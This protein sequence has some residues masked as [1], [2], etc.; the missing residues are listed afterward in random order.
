MKKL[1]SVIFLGLCLSISGQTKRTEL[2]SENFGGVKVS[3]QKTEGADGGLI[4]TTMLSFQNQKYQ[5]ISDLKYIA[6]SNKE[7]LSTLISNFE[8]A[9]T[10]SKSGEKSEMEFEGE[11]NKFKITADG[12]SGQ[13]T[14]WSYRGAS[15]FIWMHPKNITKI[16]ETL[17]IIKVNYDGE[18]KK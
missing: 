2:F 17:K 12:K 9:L 15:G 3:Q 1:L 13:I 6:V 18:I 4:I 14:I 11:K 10:F 16:I 5:Q 7:D 8:E